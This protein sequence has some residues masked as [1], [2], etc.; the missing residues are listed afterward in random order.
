MAAHR[1][2]TVFEDEEGLNHESRPRP[3]RW[4]EFCEPVESSMDGTL[5]VT[6]RVGTT[7][8]TGSSE[9]VAVDRFWVE[10]RL[11]RSHDPA[12]FAT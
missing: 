8:W 6:F 4:R 11:Q 5:G 9:Q 1:R 3:S 12:P 7:T 2:K 10:P